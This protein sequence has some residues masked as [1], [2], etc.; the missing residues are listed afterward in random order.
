VSVDDFFV[1]PA[2]PVSRFAAG[3]VPA[4]AP[5]PV[6][7]EAQPRSLLLP[8]VV[9]AVA[10]LALLVGLAVLAWPHSSGSGGPDPG[11]AR[12]FGQQTRAQLPQ[13][14][15]SEDCAAAVR[16]FPAI[17]KDVKARAAFVDGCLHP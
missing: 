4:P 15:A 9:G 3:P 12:L 5:I 13:P 16:A 2:A 14:V 6:A 7:P 17:D 11:M 10:L 8:V 1:T